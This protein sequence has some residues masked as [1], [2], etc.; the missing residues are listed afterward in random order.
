MKYIRTISELYKSTYKSAADQLRTDH[1]KRADNIMSW[2]TEKG[3]SEFKRIDRDY[4]H[5][6]EFNNNNLK[7]VKE[8]FLGKFYIVDIEE[9]HGYREGAQGFF[10]KMI[11]EWNNHVYIELVINEENFFSYMK[12]QFG[13]PESRGLQFRRDFKF[14]NRKDA[15]QFRKYLIELYDHKDFDFLVDPRNLSINKFY[16][17]E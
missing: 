5:P 3:D 17:S 11:S 6:F 13:K 2:A 15:L 9:T 14:D 12:I 8:H 16:T 4:P 10:I 7:D 1:P